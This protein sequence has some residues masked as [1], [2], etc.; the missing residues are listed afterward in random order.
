LSPAVNRGY[1]PRDVGELITK[2]KS[3]VTED[4]IGAGLA[5]GA[6]GTTRLSRPE[7]VFHFFVFTIK[8]FIQN[9]CLVRASALAYSNLLALVPMLAI[10][11]SVSA[12][13]L[14][15]EGDK[16][17]EQFVEWVVANITPVAAGKA[18][19]ENTDSTDAKVI[20][21]EM[22][23]QVVRH[24]NTF[25]NNIRGGALSGWAMAFLV[26]LV[27]SMLSRVED[28]FNDIW[29]VSKGRTFFTRLVTYWSAMT[30]GPICLIAAIGMNTTHE[31]AEFK[32]RIAQW[33]WLGSVVH[34][35]FA[36]LPYIVLSLG[37]GL[38][39]KVMPN[40]KVQ[41][42]AALVGGIFGG[43]LWQLNNL[44]GV[45]FVSRTVTNHKIYGSMGLI[46]VIMISMYL[47]W[48]ILLFG[49]QVAYAYQNRR[50]YVQDRIVE[51][52]NHKGKEILALRIMTQIGLRFHKGEGPTSA[53]EL[54]ELLGVPSRLVVDIVDTLLDDQL[55]FEINEEDPAYLPAQPLNRISFAVVIEAVRSGTGADQTAALEPGADRV[56]D[57]YTQVLAAELDCAG[58][59]TIQDLAV[60]LSEA[61]RSEAEEAVP[62][63]T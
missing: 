46:P 56:T 44:A 13:I 21:D 62:T 29:G 14:K 28:T 5:T 4:F 59:I 35:L 22:Q 60:E 27:I 10:A 20:D 39:Y 52:L 15:K 2:L 33:Q 48:L 12:V 31:L 32:E 53:Q 7:R 45:L 37:F 24:I 57:E 9:R 6:A 47:G 63:A 36:A 54:A 17:I 3:I 41:W 58:K 19:A 55:V 25:V 8:S 61:E 18:K 1:I 42:R 11:I 38:F 49:A 34:Y 43:C 50:A 26:F 16:P 30:L 23:T 51:N 40:T